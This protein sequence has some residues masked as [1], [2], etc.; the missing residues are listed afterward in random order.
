MKKRRMLG[1]KGAALIE[2][3]LVLPVLLMLLMG[4]IDFG[5]LAFTQIN[6][7]EAVQEGSIYASTHPGDPSGSILRVLG[8]VDSP[9]IAAGK[10]TVSCDDGVIKVSV[11]HPVTTITPLL[12]P[13]TVTLTAVVITDRFS[14]VS[15][16]DST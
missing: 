9:A 3:A 16:V 8:S 4:V 15:C 10:V 12:L 6:L 1:E 14:D 13:D 5:R 2:F 11:A 7:N